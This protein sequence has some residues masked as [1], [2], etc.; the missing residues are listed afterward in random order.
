MKKINVSWGDGMSDL[1]LDLTG[2]RPRILDVEFDG[3][4]LHEMCGGETYY[5]SR[6]GYS[7]AGW[8][9]NLGT[10]L[11]LGTYRVDTV[12]NSFQCFVS[13]GEIER[14]EEQV[15]AA[16][17]YTS[18]TWDKT[19]TLRDYPTVLKIGNKVVY[20]DFEINFRELLEVIFS[21]QEL[22]E[23]CEID[24]VTYKRHGHRTLRRTFFS[25][26]YGEEEV[27]MEF[28]NL[29]SMGRTPSPWEF[30]QEELEPFRAGWSSERLFQLLGVRQ[31]EDGTF[32]KA[33]K[34]ADEWYLGEII[35]GDPLETGKLTAGWQ[36]L[37]DDVLVRFY[38]RSNEVHLVAYAT[39]QEAYEKLARRLA[40]HMGEGEEFISFVSAHEGG[41]YA[42]Y[43]LIVPKVSYLLN[44]A[45]PLAELR[46]ELAR[47]VREDVMD[48]ARQWVEN[49]NDQAILE[50][51][52]DDLVV[53]IGDSMAAGN[54]QPGTEE[55]RN[56]YF[57][58]QAQTTA[59]E[60]KKFSDNY[61]VMRIFRHLAATGRFNCEIKA[62][63]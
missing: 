38:D 21:N 44:P 36:R 11:P 16:V 52:P 60:L 8:I 13:L 62:V 9:E 59:G 4:K 32:V 6:S 26:Q 29:C 18:H 43:E 10:L 27:T 39:S 53:T 37:A 19:A 5:T 22:P 31:L 47:K 54:C 50:T 20:C 56:R 49:I 63:G 15:L 17:P 42:E 7:G 55:F 14:H 3:E 48:H 25:D 33:M 41:R 1:F 34:I 58:G 24:G 30:F 23:R 45:A 51:V 35:D 40:Y 57:P 46:K 61:N 12:H 28:Y 2:K